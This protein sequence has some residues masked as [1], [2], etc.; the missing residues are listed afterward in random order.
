MGRNVSPQQNSTTSILNAFSTAGYAGVTI[1]ATGARA[2]LSPALTANSLVDLINESGSAGEI[3]HLAIATVDTTSRT[4][5]IVVTVDG[6]DIYDYT[7]A[8]MTNSNTGCALAGSLN[9][10]TTLQL[11]PIKYKSSIRVQYASSLTETGK[12]TTYLVRNQ[13]Q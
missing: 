6:V 2:A 9:S 1:N 12:F 11:P 5:R 8:A 3:S 10:S 4:L 13:V 7:S